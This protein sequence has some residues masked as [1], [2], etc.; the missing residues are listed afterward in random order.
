MDQETSHVDGGEQRGRPVM[1]AEVLPEPELEFG[2]GGRH[3]DPRFG[4]SNYGPADLDEPDRRRPIRV[5]LVGPADLLPELRAWLERCRDPIPGKDERYPN[6]FTGFPGCDVDRGL[7]TTLVLS[8]RTAAVVSKTTLREIAKAP[9]ANAL[10][11]AVEAYSQEAR[12]LAEQN[13]IDVLLLARPQELA[14]TQRRNRG[15]KGFWLLRIPP[16]ILEPI[17]VTPSIRLRTSTISSRPNC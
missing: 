16:A 12:V 14:D 1:L 10:S 13:R 2:G 9:R 5:G 3:V 15:G 8:D 17:S 6:L 7:L 11:L 4:I